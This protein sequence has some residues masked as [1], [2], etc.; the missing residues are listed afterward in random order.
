M[1]RRRSPIWRPACR[2]PNRPLAPPV[3]TDRTGAY[4]GRMEVAALHFAG[5]PED[6]A[7]PKRLAAQGA[8]HVL[9]KGRAITGIERRRGPE[10]LIELGVRETKRLVHCGHPW[11]GTPLRNFCSM[12]L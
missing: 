3:L 6:G 5:N 9:E 4:L 12:P 10:D 8:G 7:I 1:Q 2:R 11:E